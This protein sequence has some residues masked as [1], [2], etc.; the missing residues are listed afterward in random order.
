MTADAPPTPEIRSVS[1]RPTKLQKAAPVVDKYLGR[2][3][4]KKLTVFLIGCFFLWLGK[5][6]PSDFVFLAVSYIGGQ[7][8]IDFALAWRSG[9]KRI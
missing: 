2:F 5:V 3:I 9:G 1:K 7:S 6:A 8:T 4:S